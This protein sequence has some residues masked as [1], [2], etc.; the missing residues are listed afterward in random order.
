MFKTCTFRP[1]ITLTL[2]N[3]Y[4]DESSR[5][6]CP[7]GRPPFKRLLCCP[8]SASKSQETHTSMITHL[9]VLY[10]DTAL[11]EYCCSCCRDRLYKYFEVRAYGMRNCFSGTIVMNAYVL[12]TKTTNLPLDFCCTPSAAGLNPPNQEHLPVAFTIPNKRG[13]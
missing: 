11:P 10:N 2:S 6:F 7:E 5:R 13:R 1:A 4:L 3:F 12:V 8:S 9:R